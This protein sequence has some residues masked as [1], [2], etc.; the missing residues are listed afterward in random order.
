MYAV[1]KGG[2][3]EE[4]QDYICP[5]S[6]PYLQEMQST[7]DFICTHWQAGPQ[8]WRGVEQR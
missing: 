5:S 4:K 1:R 3:E 6:P 2:V 8:R 7:K